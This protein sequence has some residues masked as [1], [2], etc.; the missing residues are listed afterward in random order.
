VKRDGR[1][2]F[3]RAGRNVIIFGDDRQTFSGSHVAS[4]L[5]DAMLRIEPADGVRDNYCYGRKE[6]PSKIARFLTFQRAGGGAES[7]AKA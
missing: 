3:A 1:N 6:P 4:Q 2:D 5:T 7:G